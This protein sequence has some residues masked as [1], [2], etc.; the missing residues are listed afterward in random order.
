MHE[1]LLHCK[2]QGIRVKYFL[3]T[4]GQV[5]EWLE[6][7]VNSADAEKSLQELFGFLHTNYDQMG[8]RV[9]AIQGDSLSN[10]IPLSDGYSL[11][12]LSPT[13]N[14]LNKFISSADYTNDNAGPG[15]Q[16][17]ANW[18]ST[19][20]KIENDVEYLLLTSDAEKYSLVRIDT[21]RSQELEKM[22]CV[23]QSPHHGAENNH[24]NAFWKK[25]NRKTATPIVFSVGRNG[26]NHPSKNTISSFLKN[27]YDI[28][29]TNNTGALL[30]LTQ[31][32]ELCKTLINLDIY[33]S[34]VVLSHSKTAGDQSF[35]F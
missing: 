10:T 29:S 5:P 21:K 22:L 2:E 6:A 3:H 31:N 23:G 13:Q 7:A 12:I 28:Y 25:R 15:E 30:S 24:N 8:I 33:S 32:S 20:L 11:K 27:E 16:P 35:S 17:K 14:E 18:L 1:L 26:Y 4:C 34:S 9:A 19:I